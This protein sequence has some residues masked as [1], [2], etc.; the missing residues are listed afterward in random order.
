MII[1]SIKSLKSR[2]TL[3]EYDTVIFNVKG[4]EIRY[5]VTEEYLN[6]NDE[7]KNALIF[8][9][10]GLDSFEFCKKT[11]GYKP[12]SG[13]WPCSKQLDYEALTRCVKALY[14]VI[15]GKKTKMENFKFLVKWDEDT[16]PVKFFISRAQANKFINELVVRN[17]VS[18]IELI[19]IAKRWKV[20]RTSKLT[21]A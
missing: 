17:D 16:D 18:N 20:S 14:E 19:E 10:L 5:T 8:K 3:R 9:T 7:G 21:K 4:E 1:D 2:E 11:Y 12:E 6:R 15:G 13:D